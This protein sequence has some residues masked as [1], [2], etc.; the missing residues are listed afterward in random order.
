MS[1]NNLFNKKIGSTVILQAIL[2]SN[3]MDLGTYLV[4]NYDKFSFSNFT[5]VE[6]FLRM[7]LDFN[8]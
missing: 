7:E 5:F 1:E 4:S 3:S 6:S 8:L 2:I